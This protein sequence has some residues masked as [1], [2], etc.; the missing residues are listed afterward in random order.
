MGESKIFSIRLPVEEIERLKE[1][2]WD[3]RKNVNAIV[4]EAINEYLDKYLQKK[5]VKK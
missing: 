3:L 5:K 1:A 4:R 2:K